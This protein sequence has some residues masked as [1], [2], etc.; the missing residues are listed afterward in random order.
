MMTATDLVGDAAQTSGMM[1]ALR[2]YA[3]KDLRVEE[4]AKPDEPGPGQ[5]PVRNRF[6]GICGTDLHEYSYGPIFI[7]MEPH[8]FT[9]AYGVQVLGHEFGGVVESVGEGVTSVKPGDRVSIQPLV[10]PRAGDYFADRGLFHLSPQLALVGLSW[11]S[12]GMAEWALVNDYNVAPVPAELSDE[13]AVLVE[14]AAVAVYA[15]DRGRCHRR[16]QRARH[17]RR[18]DRALTLLAAK[19]AG[20]AQLFV[21]DLNDTRL[22]FMKEMLPEIVTLNPKWDNVG[23]A[24]RTATEG[25]VGCDVAIECVGNEQALKACLDAVRKQ[26]VVVQTS[27]HPHDNPLDW[28]AVTFKD[29]DIR[30]SW[31]YPTTTGRASSG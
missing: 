9:G 28:F 19:A 14:P 4:I 20:A 22:G 8:P 13:E 18:T 23:E 11:V 5:V 24:I 15:C 25:K 21:S 7:P 16:V 27:L 26:G 29:V 17:R 31:A 2:F 6:V 3:A 30:G 10:M 12:G 1:K